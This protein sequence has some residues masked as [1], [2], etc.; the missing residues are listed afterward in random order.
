MG[1]N[2]KKKEDKPKKSDFKVF[3]KKR[4]PIYLGIIAI[5]VVFII[6]ELTKTDLQ[7]S[8]PDNLTDEEK[9]IVEI[10][11][12]YNGPNEKGLTVMNAIKEQIAAE[13]PDEKIY[14][15]KKTKVDLN[16]SKKEDSTENYKVIL[17]F[18]SYKGKID[19]VWNVNLI[20]K[21]I[22]AESSNAKH[23][24]DIVDYYD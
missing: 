10:L 18:E 16:I 23:I 22:K 17:I 12:S 3:L 6:P 1:K 20:T 4:A 21:E 24:I 5:F 8:F 15:N 13:Y 9:Q 11:M 7:S 19:Y 2:I 14:D